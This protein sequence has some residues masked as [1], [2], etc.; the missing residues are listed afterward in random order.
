MP[1]SLRA[2]DFARFTLVVAVAFALLEGAPACGNHAAPNPFVSGS[3]GAGGGVGDGGDVGAGAGTPSVD[4]TLGGPCTVDSQCDDA[5]PCTFD[6]CDASLARCRFIPDDTLCQNEFVCDGQ[7]VC[8]NSHGCVAGEPKTCSDGNA[9]TIDSCEAATGACLSEARDADADG[10]PDVHCGGGDCADEEPLVSSKQDEVCANGVDDDCD[11]V[12]DEPECGKPSHDDCFTPLGIATPGTYGMSTVAAKLDYGSSCALGNP[13]AAR[14]VV[15]ALSIPAGSYDVT[16]TARTTSPDVTVTLAGLCGKPG[17]E[18]ACGTGYPHAQSGRFAKLRARGVGAAKPMV[19]P[20]Y[21]ATDSP[22]AVTLRY[23][24]V[25]AG[26]IP[27]NETCGSALVLAEGVPQTAQ[28]VGVATDLSTKCGTATGELVYRFEL[29]EARD[30]DLFASSIDG[31][32][33]PGISLR[34]AGCAL[35]TDEVTCSVAP[36]AGDS[37]HIF[38]HALV[39]GVYFVAVAATAPTDALLTL[40]TSPPTPLPADENCAASPLLVPGVTRDVPLAFHQDDVDTGCL[41]GGTDAAYALEL[42]AASDVLVVGRYSNGDSAAVSIAKLG[43]TAADELSC[44]VGNLSPTRARAHA[45]Q[46]GS[47]RVIAESEQAQPMQ[48]TAFVR[49]KVPPTLVPFADGCADALTIGP[50]G[51]FFQGNTSNAKADFDAGCDQG[52]QPKGTAPDQ[53]L[54]LVLAAPKRVVFDMQGSGYSTVLAVRQGSACPGNELAKACAVGYYPDRSFLDLTLSPG[55]YF[56]Q[57]DGFNG[58][59]GPWFLDV[60]L[61]DLPP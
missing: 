8:S 41:T 26:A 19:L 54:R 6:A 33:R 47:Y 50:F 20:V 29:S 4:P 24:L 44:A 21:V 53:L 61:A 58:Q 32:G 48:L 36:T 38:R 59:Y 60:F 25:A 14:D 40:S 37:A 34:T 10:D 39:P 16:L 43:C 13:P 17:T 28:L 9:C 55:T 56:V 49:P 5:L 46:A 57:I 7:E 51:G 1:G 35:A 31:D 2:G 15:A 52:K 22:T 30:V 27:T 45:L 3:G 12:V 42:S 23:E 18:L 11:G